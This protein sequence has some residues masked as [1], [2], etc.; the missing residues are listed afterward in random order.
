M[1]LRN[2]LIYPNA[3]ENYHWTIKHANYTAD[4]FMVFD[5]AKQRLR[6]KVHGEYSRFPR[7]CQSLYQEILIHRTIKLKPFVWQHILESPT[8][9]T[10]SISEWQNHPII[11]SIKINP[12]WRQFSSQGLRYH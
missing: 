5:I 12:R 2:L 7:L 4:L 6:L 8:A 9:A 3:A 11:T 1:P 10:D